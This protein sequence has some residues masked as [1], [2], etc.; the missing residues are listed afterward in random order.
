MTHSSRT[1]T[2]YWTRVA[3]GN[4]GMCGRPRGADGTTRL[5]AKDARRMRKK[6]ADRR[7]R[8][9][10]EGKCPECGAMLRDGRCQNSWHRLDNAI[11]NANYRA[12]RLR[13]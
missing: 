7:A 4:C 13:P 5:C 6:I 3:A 11:N 2:N 12:R 8:L 10:A 9:R 1:G